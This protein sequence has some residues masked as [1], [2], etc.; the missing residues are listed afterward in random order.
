LIRV[1]VEVVKQRAQAS[2][3]TSFSIFKRTISREGFKG[4]YRGY[5]STVV[6]E[7]PFSFIQFPIW[8]FLKK[9]WSISQRHSIKPWQSTICGA[10][11]GGMAALI[12]TPL[13]V[14]KTKIMLAKKGT[15]TSTGN[16][17]TVL[18]LVFKEKGFRGYKQFK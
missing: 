15:I 10:I 5:L 3:A 12:T 11:A 4:L 14:A 13:D 1:P 7:V 2:S 18:K 16:I 9:N 8:E 6:R 17:L